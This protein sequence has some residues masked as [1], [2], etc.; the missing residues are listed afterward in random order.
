[1]KRIEVSAKWRWQD[2]FKAV[3]THYLI[4]KDAVETP[5]N[6]YIYQSLVQAKGRASC[7]FSAKVV[8]TSFLDLVLDVERIAKEVLT[9]FELAIWW[10]VFVEEGVINAAVRAKEWFKKITTDIRTRLG[11]AFEARRIDPV[12]AYFTPTD[13]RGRAPRPGD[14]QVVGIPRR[15]HQPPKEVNVLDDM[16]YGSHWEYIPPDELPMEGTA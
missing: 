11:R 9:T 14:P 4:A 5:L 6:A 2:V 3:M 13:L 12:K 8:K 10:L 16:K 1:M 15:A 7:T